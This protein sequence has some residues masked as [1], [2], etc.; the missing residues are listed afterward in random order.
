MT[1]LGIVTDCLHLFE[2]LSDFIY[3]IRALDAGGIEITFSTL[4]K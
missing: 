2:A 3:R 4:R 1:A